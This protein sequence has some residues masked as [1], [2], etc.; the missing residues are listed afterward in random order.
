MTTYNLSTEIGNNIQINKTNRKMKLNKFFMG[1][2]GALALTACSSEDPGI[3]TPTPDLGESEPRYMSVTIRNIDMGGTRAP[4]D[5]SQ[6]GNYEEGYSA[7]N[8]VNSLRFY[9]FKADGTPAPVKFNGESY[10]D[11]ASDKIEAGDTD[12]PNTEKI[13][14]AIIVI[15][16][17][18]SEGSRNDIKQMVALINYDKI[19]AKL[20]VGAT[21]SAKPGN[22][23]LDELTG[24][25]SLE[26][27]MMDS[28]GGF[29][30]SSSSFYAPTN[31]IAVAIQDEDIKATEQ[32]AKDN[33][34]D[35]YVERTLAKVRVTEAWDASLTKFENVKLSGAVGANDPSY[36]A[37]ALKD[38]AGNNILVGNTADSPQAYVIFQNWDLWWTADKT[39]LY[40][41]VDNWTTDKLNWAWNHPEYKRS[42]WAENPVGVTLAKHNH[43]YPSRKL[44][45]GTASDYTD[46]TAYCLENAADPGMDGWKKG[47]N[48]DRE[49]TNRTLVYLSALIVTLNDDHTV[50]TPVDLAEWAGYKYTKESVMAAMFESNNN[51]FYFVNVSST[52]NPPVVDENNNI[53]T[54]GE[55]TYKFI[56]V[57]LSDLE[58]VSGMMAGQAGDTQENDKRYQSFLNLISE[59]KGLW[60]NK[61]DN[62]GVE[63]PEVVHK[64]YKKTSDGTYQ[65]VLIEEVNT[66]LESVGGCKVWDGG[67]TYYY[68][69]LEHLGKTG[70]Y[71]SGTGENTKTTSFN[72]GVVRNHIYEVQ[73]EKVTGLGT[74]ILTY[75]DDDDH[76]SW[77]DITPQ[78]P[79]PDAYYLGARVNIL[80]WRVVGNKVTLDW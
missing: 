30:M 14:N 41:K 70:E 6:D 75:L 17:N 29:L 61:V 67:N 66:Q 39:Y 40:K 46:Y 1:F 59:G 52:E 53:I 5:Q 35:V 21:N 77:E 8:A 32:L 34:V 36:T 3:S 50:A 51:Q 45:K 79:T 47:Y 57:K 80:S 38:K 22:L 19:A 58:L 44:G 20:N 18:T 31:G 60:K 78:K 9:F 74:P 56:P 24:I 72:H 68:H 12:M 55:T 49:T 62:D 25:I 28:K 63:Y 69:E 4:G 54:S 13:L 71:T 7:E 11:C 48:P 37:I 33:P 2:F 16:T 23:T 73:L 15:N 42:Y 27:D 65:E 43:I 76:E 64:I 10:Y 26:D